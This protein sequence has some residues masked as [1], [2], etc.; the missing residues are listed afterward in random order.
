MIKIGKETKMTYYHFDIEMDIDD[1]K[2]LIKYALK[3]IKKDE[4]ALINYAMNDLLK[5]RVE[6]LKEEKGK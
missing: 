1:R 3:T 4:E 2:K 6:E 5:K